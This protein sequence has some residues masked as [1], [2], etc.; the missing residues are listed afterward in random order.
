M[1]RSSPV[2]KIFLFLMCFLFSHLVLMQVMTKTTTMTKILRK[3]FSLSTRES[4]W[5]EIPSTAVVYL[6]KALDDCKA[7]RLGHLLQTVPP[8]IDVW[9]LHNHNTMTKESDHVALKASIDHVRRLNREHVLYNA[10][11]SE[12]GI[13]LFDTATSVASK[14]SF[15]RFVVQHPEY[16]HVWHIEDDVFFTGQWSHFFAHPDTEAD[17]V[18]A[19]IKRKGSWPHFEV[20]KCS[21]DQ[22]HV[23]N[24]NESMSKSS[25]VGIPCRDVLTW[26]SL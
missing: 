7:I 4:T 5:D 17:F 15:L 13:R 22:K 23:R 25:L 24:Y 14:S 3:E 18:G 6:T 1:G 19:Q 12:K 10:S 26:S 21:V 8:N 2:A 20:D 9:I 11:Q 16:K